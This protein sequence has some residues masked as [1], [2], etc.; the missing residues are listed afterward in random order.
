MTTA[1]LNKLPDDEQLDHFAYDHHRQQ[2]IM[3]IIDSL[4]TEREKPSPEELKE[5]TTTSNW[6]PGA[7][8]TLLL[9]LID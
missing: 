5:K 1:Q 6:E 8:A 3:D 9:G 4:Q 7:A 2:G